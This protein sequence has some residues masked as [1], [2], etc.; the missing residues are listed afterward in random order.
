MKTAF[1]SFVV[2]YLVFSMRKDDLTKGTDK[3]LE[4]RDAVTEETGRR[5]KQGPQ[6]PGEHAK[7]SWGAAKGRYQN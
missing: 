4:D 1:Q 6:E 3:V 5:S 2:S 7:R